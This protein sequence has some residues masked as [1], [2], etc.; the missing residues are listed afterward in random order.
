MSHAAK[1]S[2]HKPV[3]TLDPSRV[4]NLSRALYEL[5][6][7][8]SKQSLLALH[9]CKTPYTPAYISRLLNRSLNIEQVVAIHHAVIDHGETHLRNELVAEAHCNRRIGRHD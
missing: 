9:S 8:H 1:H 4:D 7:R 6:E 2:R 5:R 3:L